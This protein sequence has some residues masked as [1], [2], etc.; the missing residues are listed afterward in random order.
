VADTKAKSRSDEMLLLLLVSEMM[1]LMCGCSWRSRR[2]WPL[3]T[4]TNWPLYG[5][6]TAGSWGPHCQRS[7]L[8][9]SHTISHWWT[10]TTSSSLVS[11]QYGVVFTATNKT[12]SVAANFVPDAAKPRTRRNIRY[13][14]SLILAH[15]L[16]YVK[17]C[18][19]QCARHWFICWFRCY[20][21][22]F[23]LF[24]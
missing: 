9:W 7:G 13:A 14:L 20:I 22:C 6:L 4:R 1:M 12:H 24:A 21:N 8:T 23:C 5:H 18:V 15:S 16:H 3:W 19:G 10:E 2:L 17:S 11:I